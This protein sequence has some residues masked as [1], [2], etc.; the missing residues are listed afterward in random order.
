MIASASTI[1]PG[2]VESVRMYLE[3]RSHHRQPGAV[4]SSAW[5]HFYDLCD[6]LLRR[7][8]AKQGMNGSDLDD[9]VQNTWVRL[10]KNLPG[11]AYDPSRGSFCTWLYTLAHSSTM[12][13]LRRKMRNKAVSLGDEKSVEP[14]DTRQAVAPALETAE[15][16]AAVEGILKI[17]RDHISDENYRLMRLR[18][19]DGRSVQETADELSISH[20]QVW[21]RE[22]R[23]KKK[24]QQLLKS[25]PHTGMAA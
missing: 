18:W 4:E 17:A 7:F 23:L 2:L 22:H 5:G 19:I 3:A 24:L 14:T 6:P 11:F 13:H 10:I 1:G 21:Y 15:A 16:H 25:S 8:V 12:D 20:K 9:C